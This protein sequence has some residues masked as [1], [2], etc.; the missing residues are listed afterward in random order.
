M[1]WCSIIEAISYGLIG[2]SKSAFRKPKK[3]STTQWEV[4]GCG[5]CA[6]LQEVGLEEGLGAFGGGHQ[7]A[8]RESQAWIWLLLILL[9]IRNRSLGRPIPD[10]PY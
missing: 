7:E 8:Y 3:P 2:N 1:P 4:S 5:T 10:P 9:K 6:L